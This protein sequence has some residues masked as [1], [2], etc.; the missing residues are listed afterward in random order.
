MIALLSGALLAGLA[1]APHCA[2]MCG[3]I[4]A[5]A[6]GGPAWH[7]GRLITYALL[8][9]T[10]GAAGQ[11]LPPQVTLALSVL[12]LVLFS[13]HL[14][15]L[16]HLRPPAAPRLMKLGGWLLRRGGWAGRLVTGL[17]T[18]LL[19]C[20]LIYAALGM[21]APAGSAL[22]GAAVM[23]TFWL[24][25][26]PATSLAA[27]GLRRLRRHIGRRWMAAAVLALG[28]VAISIRAPGSIDEPPSCHSS[29]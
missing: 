10:A 4:A 25:T 28:L 27:A 18:G 1:G 12:L 13:A 14:A 9:A 7:A 24:S 15:G 11:W 5:A 6:G 8:G 2:G 17:L 26:V 19:P 3:G 20:G 22:A 21:A 29:P 23:A 16:V